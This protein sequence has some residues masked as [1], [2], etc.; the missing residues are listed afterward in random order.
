MRSSWWPSSSTRTFISIFDSGE[1]AS[2]R[3]YYVLDYVAGKPIDRY[4]RD[5]SVSLESTLRLF[6]KVCDAV[7]YAH[8]SGVLHRD[9][10]PSNILVDASGEAKILDLGLA[11]SLTED[12]LSTVS[13]THQVVGTLPYMS[14]EQSRGD[15]DEIGARSDVYALGVVLYN[16]LTGDFPYPVNGAVGQTLRHIQETPPQPPRRQW[17][18]DS[19]IGSGSKVASC[20]IDHDL[21][22]LVLKALSKDVTRRYQSALELADDVRHYLAGEPILA[23]R[24]SGWYLLRKTISRHRWLVMGLTLTLLVSIAFGLVMLSMYPRATGAARAQRG[25]TYRCRRGCRDFTQGYGFPRTDVLRGRGRSR[26]PAEDEPGGSSPTRRP[27]GAP[28]TSIGIRR[29]SP[30]CWKP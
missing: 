4:V 2:G 5:D 30:P 23:R 11:K 27:S 3:Q 21:E 7:Q 19:G 10:K 12:A 22:T 29:G 1:T 13:L 28:P 6:V 18:E 26:V 25:A 8:E 9:L 17:R 15:S 20:P 24:D 16:L 14:P